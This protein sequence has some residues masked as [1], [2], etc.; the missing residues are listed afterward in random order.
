MSNFDTFLN[1]KILKQ[2]NKT[3]VKIYSS[4]VR[5]REREDK[6]LFSLLFIWINRKTAVV[7]VDKNIT[8]KVML[9]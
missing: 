4:K 7:H 9:R 2:L 3:P 6:P 5:V 8:I 1:S